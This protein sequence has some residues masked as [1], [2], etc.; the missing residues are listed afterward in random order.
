ME[1]RQLQ[2]PKTTFGGFFP[3]SLGISIAYMVS[4]NIVKVWNTRLGEASSSFMEFDQAVT[5]VVLMPP[6][7]KTIKKDDPNSKR[8][9]RLLVHTCIQI[10]KVYLQ[11][12]PFKLLLREKSDEPYVLSTPTNDCIFLQ[13]YQRVW[14][15]AETTKELILEEKPRT[16]FSNKRSIIKLNKPTPI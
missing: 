8:L 11:D 7:P 15:G 12:E 13:K 4:E 1:E 6:D 3:A 10:E 16:M 5:S 2:N 14:I 9:F